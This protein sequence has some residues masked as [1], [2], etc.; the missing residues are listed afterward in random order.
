L[1]NRRLFG[2][3]SLLRVMWLD[4][5]RRMQT[6]DELPAKPPEAFN[7]WIRDSIDRGWNVAA[8]AALYVDSV[9]RSFGQHEWRYYAESDLALRFPTELVLEAG[10]EQYERLL[11]PD[12]ADEDEARDDQLSRDWDGVVRS[13][14]DEV[15]SELGLRVPNI[16]LVLNDALSDNSFRLR[17]SG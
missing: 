8:A 5:R 17:M 3:P 11:A 15:Y 12:G 9:G 10:R 13:V 1:N 16:S 14:R 7:A 6:A 2:T 4:A